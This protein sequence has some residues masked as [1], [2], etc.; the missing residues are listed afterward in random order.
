MI[1]EVLKHGAC[2]GKTRNV[3]MNELGISYRDLLQI[4]HDEREKGALILAGNSGYYLPSEDPEI[5][6]EELE[7]F[8]KRQRSRIKEISVTVPHIEREIE[9][10][11]SE[12]GMSNFEKL[13]G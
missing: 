8:A 6:L 4:V 5:A 9:R 7:H 3:L 10:I 13:L 1:Q 2:N 11:N 12:I